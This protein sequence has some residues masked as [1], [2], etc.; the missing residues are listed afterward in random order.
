VTAVHAQVENQHSEAPET[1]GSGGPALGANWR[2]GRCEFTIWAPFAKR[3]EV[4]LVRGRQTVEL[5][6][7]EQG[8]FRTQIQNLEPDSLYFLQ[9][10][11]GRQRGDPASR[12]QPQGVFGPS[13]ICDTSAFRWTD[14]QWRGIQLKDYVLYELHVGVY[15]SSGTFDALCEKISYLKSL[16]VTAVE[17]MP[18]AQFPGMRNWG[19]DGAFPFAVQNTYGGPH[20]LHRFV[21]ACHREGLAVVLDVVYN[22]LGPEGNFLGEFGPYFTDRY[23][24]PWG[25]AIN[26]D[27]PHSDHV[28][29]YFVE[30]A[31][32]WLEQFH[33]DALRLDAIHGIF[34]RNAQPFLSLLST[35]VDDL[36][37][38]CRRN[39]YLIAE[40]DLND[41][42]FVRRRE[43]G[44]Y[45]LHAQWNDDF[46]HALHAL[47]TGE[48]TGYYCDFGSLSHLRTAFQN[49]YVY[50]G[51]YSTF[52]QCRHGA[53][54][55][56]LKRSQLVVFSQNH[57]QIGNR[58]G[59]ERSGTLI[60]FEA[61]KLSAGAVLLSPF[62][63][64]LFMGEEYGETAP[65]LY[66]TD[67]SD[68]ALGIAVR[69]G[70]RA[71]FAGFHGIEEVPDPQ[72]ESTFLKSK[73]DHTVSHNGKHKYLL[74]FYK[75]LLRLRKQRAEFA[76]FEEW[77]IDSSSV[78]ECLVVRR[79][80]KG[81][82]SVIV[83]NFGNK[84]EKYILPSLHG[85]W[86]KIADSAEAKW[87]G[88]GSTVP[89]H[90]DQRSELKLELPPRSFCVF[91]SASSTRETGRVGRSR[92]GGDKHE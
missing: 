62:L 72:D 60:D 64:L 21:D 63:P 48:R 8:Y 13:R 31:L 58:G 25:Q 42:V 40:S 89:V 79:S 17:I 24:T 68:P 15:T 51:Q 23:R 49:G 37:R 47:Q 88:P 59:G 20:G 70:R 61:Q 11:G 78:G 74:D 26:F 18:V 80:S 73:L 32:Y 28:V 53:P 10:D 4:Q 83:F 81:N 67:H 85:C 36:A 75:E 34:D 87:A 39:I 33:I 6:P 22:H 3:V 52:R 65:F 16:G 45:G 2:D 19:Y 41:P 7:I 77:A 55:A 44:G 5:E 86:N 84:V 57:D 92:V 76:E 35:V 30:N 82:E 1:M 14:P 46:H 69:D 50:S 56:I 54:F 71:E 12:F 38:R 90:I 43:D 27:G 66:F 29:R 91:E 9:L